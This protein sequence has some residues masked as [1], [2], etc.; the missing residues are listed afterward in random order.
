MIT[1]PTDNHHAAD[2]VEASLLLGAKAI[3][4]GKRVISHIAA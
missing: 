2:K 1:L 3:R 4:R